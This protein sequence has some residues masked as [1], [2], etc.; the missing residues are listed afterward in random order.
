M[1]LTGAGLGVGLGLGGNFA[2]SFG[3]ELSLEE[4]E[5]VWPPLLLLRVGPPIVVEA[6]A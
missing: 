5:V 4:V 6:F 1:P 2:P 3:E